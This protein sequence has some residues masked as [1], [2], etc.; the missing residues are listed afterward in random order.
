MNKPIISIGLR[1]R[2]YAGLISLG[3]RL[4]VKLSSNPHFPSPAVSLLNL[5]AA[6]D[7]VE[8][9][10]ALWAPVG[11]HGSRSDLLDLIDKSLTLHNLIKA[12]GEY[13]Q[14][15]ALILA[16]ND[17]SDMAA[18]I[19]TSGFAMKKVKTPQ[20]LL[21]APDGLRKVVASNLNPNQVK[22]RWKKP[23]D[24]A[25]RNVY[26]YRVLRATT[27][28]IA[29]AVQIATTSRISYIDNNETG[30]VQTYTYWIVPVNNVGDGA[31]SDA[32]TV[33]VLGM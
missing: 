9:A 10:L 22:L 20:G 4:V 31:V 28:N 3:N 19:A 21:P 30:S 17:Y 15:M 25:R 27:A 13:V 26:L 32:V 8:A 24:V 6:V 1:P 11:G 23:L 33:S 14:S 16:G 2:Q 5:Q 7:N 29:N 18:I 12:E